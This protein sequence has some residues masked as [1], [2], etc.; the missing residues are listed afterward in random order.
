MKVKRHCLELKISRLVKLVSP[1]DFV[2][3]G[4]K[5]CD[6]AK[7]RG[8]GKKDAQADKKLAL[9][10]YIQPRL[11][12]SLA[13]HHDRHNEGPDLPRRSYRASMADSSMFVSCGQCL[14]WY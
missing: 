13:Q 9:G 5:E 10:I 11:T 3:N 7:G 12:D 8:K 6:G 1:L 4:M 14:I 2:K